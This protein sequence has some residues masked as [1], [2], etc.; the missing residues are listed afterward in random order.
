MIIKNVNINNFRSIERLSI[1]FD[2][3]LNVFVGMN[4]AGKTTIMDTLAIGLSWLTNRVKKGNSRGKYIPENDIRHEEALASIEICLS[5]N[6]HDYCWKTLR[7][8]TGE[9]SDKKSDLR[10]SNDLALYF[11]EKL[12]AGNPLPVIVYYPVNRLVNH[13]EANVKN[14]TLYNRSVLDVY[15]RAMSGNLDYQAFFSWFRMQDDIRN[16]IAAGKIKWLPDNK[17][18]IRHE[19]EKCIDLIDKYDI[20]KDEGIGLKQEFSNLKN[21]LINNNRIYEEAS[22]F[23]YEFSKFLEFIEKTEFAKRYGK[24]I[25]LISRVFTHVELYEDKKNGFGKKVKSNDFYPKTIDQFI[26]GFK[27]KEITTNEVEL[28]WRLFVMVSGIYLGIDGH[29]S[30]RRNLESRLDKLFIEFRKEGVLNDEL[31]QEI[32]KIFGSKTNNLGGAENNSFH[33]VKGRELETVRLAIEQFLPEYTELRVK[34]LPKPHLLINKEG[35]TFDLNQLSEGEKSLIALI[36][37]IARR[38]TI[39][40]LNSSEPLKGKGIVLIDEIDLHLHPGWQRL[41]VP[42]LLKVFSNCQFIITTH[43]PLVL[44]HIQPE[45]L[46]LLNN[47]ENTLS[48]SKARESYGKNSD[49]ILEDILGIDAR[50]AKEKKRLQ[51]LFKMI[52]RGEL[53]KAD[54]EI[55]KL[56]KVFRGQEPDLLKAKVLIKRKEILGK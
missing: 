28:V 1:D 53:E 50:P 45:N 11:Q 23:I 20:F 55:D 51:N 33:Y 56:S 17:E 9:H 21:R 22:I 32:K 25:P 4:G 16:E 37:D 39:A 40:N 18:R 7:L 3:R 34:R 8:A 44:S 27:G 6:K 35:R 10:A 12:K 43:S 41:V 19:L 26:D 15:D 24:S 29:S 2:K 30:S 48:I 13:I 54:K 46:F 31:I 47:K 14:K 49:R 5:N 36:G 38:L 42:Q 52:E